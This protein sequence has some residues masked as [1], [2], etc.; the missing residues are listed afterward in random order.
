MPRAARLN[1]AQNIRV[2]A[3]ERLIVAV[4]VPLANFCLHDRARRA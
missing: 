4:E 1:V 2:P 3:F